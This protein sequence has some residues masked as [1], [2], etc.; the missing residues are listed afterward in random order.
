[1]FEKDEILV[2]KEFGTNTIFRFGE[3][4]EIHEGNDLI[5][6]NGLVVVIP[7]GD[8]KFYLQSKYIKV[9]DYW[10]DN[11]VDER[12]VRRA[13]EDEFQLYH[14]CEELFERKFS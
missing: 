6:A 12:F 2:A 5:N 3:K 13:K 7:D 9:H 1:M 8:K 10:E 14:K 11:F 4:K